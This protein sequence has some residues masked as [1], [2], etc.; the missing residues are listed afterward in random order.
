[1]KRMLEK[2]PNLYL[3]FK[4]EERPYQVGTREPMPNR[5]IDENGKIRSE[6]LEF[7][8]EF[9][10]RML[11]GCDQFVGIPGKTVRA[12]QYVEHTLSTIEQ[13][14]VGVRKKVAR[15]NAIRLYHLD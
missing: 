2:H 4:V 11:L 13:L 5:M 7:F 6:W 3:G 9:P 15:D 12:P 1:M 10:D 14:P 8:E